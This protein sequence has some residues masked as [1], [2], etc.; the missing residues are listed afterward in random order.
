MVRVTTL[1]NSLPAVLN[2]LTVLN[3]CTQVATNKLHQTLVF[4]LTAQ[5]GH[6]Q[7][8]VDPVKEFGEI[9][10]HRYAITL[11]DNAVDFLNGLLPVSV[12]AKPKTVA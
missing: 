1:G 5:Q 12:R 3:A 8:M 2:T 6:Q 9:H 7:V 11:L 4:Y 10:I